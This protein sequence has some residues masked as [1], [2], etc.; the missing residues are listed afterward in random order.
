MRYRSK[1]SASCSISARVGAVSAR[2]STEPLD[3]GGWL[4]SSI[5]VFSYT[6]AL[7]LVAT[8]R[9]A[10][11]SQTAPPLHGEPTLRR[12]LVRESSSFPARTLRLEARDIHRRAMATSYHAAIVHACGHDTA[13]DAQEL[14]LEPRRSSAPERRAWEPAEH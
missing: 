3:A 4:V 11:G 1:I 9:P 10:R 14:W 7:A 12:R 8:S 6:S 2:T 5:T 13:Y